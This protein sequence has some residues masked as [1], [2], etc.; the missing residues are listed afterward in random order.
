MAVKLQDLMGSV[1]PEL[2][3]QPVVKHLRVTLGDAP[4][5]ESDHAVLVWEPPRVVPR[6]AA[7]RAALAA[8][9]APA[10]VADAEPE[11]EPVQFGADGPPMLDPRTAF[12]VH[13]AA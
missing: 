7:P 3:Y 4:V 9:L 6:Y 1:V 2:R 10:P 12:A 11:G 5:A 13:T 8:E